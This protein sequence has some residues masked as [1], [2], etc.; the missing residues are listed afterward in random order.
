MK[1]KEYLLLLLLLG[2]LKNAA[3]SQLQISG[4]VKDSLTRAVV[5]H[6]QVVI[7]SLKVDQLTDNRGRFVVRNIKPGTYTLYVVFAEYRTHRR[8]IIV[9]KE[10]ISL[11]VDLVPFDLTLNV[12]TVRQEKEEDFGWRRLSAVEGTS[13]YAGK[14]TEVILLEN[15]TLNLAANNA[16]QI[17]SQIAG[18]N[19][20]ENNDGG[21]QLNIGGRGLDPN[22]SANFNTR[23][24]GYDISADVLGYPESYY[25]PPPEA[26]AEI[27]VIR[28]A[29]ALQYGTQFG[30]L[31]N[32]KFRQPIENKKIE[33]I[34]RQAYASN[35]LFTTFNSI[36]GTLRKFSYY[37]YCNYKRGDGFRPNS[38]FEATNL[39]THLA[40][41]FSPNTTISGEITYLDY[42]AKQPGG[43]WDSKFEEDIFFSNRERNWFDVRWLLWSVKL[44]QK[45]SSKTDLSLNAYGL[46]G[47]RK[48]LGFR[49]AFS[50]QVDDVNEPRDLIIGQ[51]K[52]WAAEARLL[53]RYG[54]GTDKTGKEKLGVFVIGTKYYQSNNTSQQGP[55]STS[56]DPDFTY[57]S[58]EFR[59][60]PN[61]SS[62][63]YPNLNVSVFGENIFNLS[64]KLSVTPG[65]RFEYIRTES[66]GSYQ[67]LV[68]DGANNVI[69]DAVLTDDRVFDRRFVLFGLGMSYQPA[70]VA[71]VY[72]NFTQNYRSVTFSDLR[73]VSPTYQIDPNI[74]DE[75]G[76]TADLGLRGR[77]GNF[78]QYDFGIYGLL[79]ADRLGESLE[80]E[81]QT[82]SD[83]TERE[84]GRLLRK[85][86]NVGDAFIYG[87][88][89]LLDWNIGNSFWQDNEK[90]RL[91]YFTNIA[92]TK[93]E[94]FHSLTPGIE[95]KEVEFIPDW[96]IKTG[97]R[98][99]FGDFDGSLQLTYLSEQFTDA[100]NAPDDPNTLSGI[101]GTIPAYTIMDL[102][103]AYTWKMLKLE[104]GSN[105]LLDERYFT[106]RATGYPG[107][108]IIPSAPRTF[109][110]GLQLRI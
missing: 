104:A 83:G 34:S 58:E 70:K 33:L 29:A 15:L 88:E 72:A 66:D 16:R 108:G 50:S 11:E 90:F 110:V 75:N 73:V 32:F 51:F 12:V 94:Y 106:R 109:Y 5:E 18:L 85:R 37:T 56:S 46:R 9:G 44:E 99:G 101:R 61:Q 55:G 102:S 67:N 7:A 13:I 30:G 76:Y 49:S 78:L 25:T 91:S 1:I 35:N 4:V 45:F 53:T 14:K 68:F 64:P 2:C 40:Y 41:E 27:Q 80:A 77:L 23:Q 57:A 107:P 93:S 97:F 47:H 48:S 62:F 43:L 79:Y 3:W 89:S 19:I 21:L 42:L 6:A 38:Q 17:Y 52:N 92:F 69:A 10:D 87:F 63:R 82:F 39:H 98:F 28:G 20:Y 105:N 81:V 26:L 24:N 54:L 71:E 60:Y 8:E 65:F 100:S 103:L 95:G 84:T 59:Y 31:V 96:N 86:K 22:R 74:S 36:S